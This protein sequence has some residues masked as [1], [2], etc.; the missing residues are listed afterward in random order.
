MLV[1]CGYKVHLLSPTP[2][3]EKDK[4]EVERNLGERVTIHRH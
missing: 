2:H 3:L 1:V 4:T